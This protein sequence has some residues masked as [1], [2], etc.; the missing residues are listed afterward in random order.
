MLLRTTSEKEI[1]AEREIAM[2]HRHILTQ[3]H[4][5]LRGYP[6][7]CEVEL[8]F[9]LAD[10][11]KF[12]LKCNTPKVELC[13]E[14]RTRL[15]DLLGPGNVKLIAAAPSTRESTSR[16]T[17]NGSHQRQNFASQRRMASV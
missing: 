7:T 12:L 6:G 16:G 17:G 13:P 15:D 3:L 9:V 11:A 1:A 14:L 8:A 4:E 5:I 10:G 2:A